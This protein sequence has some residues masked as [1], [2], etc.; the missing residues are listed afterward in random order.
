MNVYRQDATV[1]GEAYKQTAPKP[2]R[3]SSKCI[4]GGK[5][6]SL[7][8]HVCVAIRLSSVLKHDQ[9]KE[10][11]PQ[12]LQMKSRRFFEWMW[13][14]VSARAKAAQAQK[15]KQKKIRF[16]AGWDVST[17]IPAGYLLGLRNNEG[18]SSGR[19]NRQTIASWEQNLRQ[20]LARR[21]S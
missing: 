1:S 12:Y 4:G 5:N 14:T 20:V 7:L 16:D 6:K 15:G 3:K 17:I 10:E 11:I 8:T 21:R 18:C 13:L 19:N 9:E 2:Q